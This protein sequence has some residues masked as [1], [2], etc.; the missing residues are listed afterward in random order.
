M[1]NLHHWLGIQCSLHD[2]EILMIYFRTTSDY[3]FNHQLYSQILQCCSL[4]CC[5]LPVYLTIQRAHLPQPQVLMWN[6]CCC[7]LLVMSNSVP[8]FCSIVVYKP[9]P[10]HLSEH[11]CFLSVMLR[12]A[13]RLITSKQQRHN[14]RH[15]FICCCLPQS[16]RRVDSTKSHLP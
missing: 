1:G 10:S 16:L 12:T 15:P 2:S 7:C 5:L 9:A 13:G 8:Q 14:H 6:D 3:F 4:R 11:S